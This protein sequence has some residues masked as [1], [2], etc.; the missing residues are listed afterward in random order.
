MFL[1]K[2][3]QHKE[4]ARLPLTHGNGGAGRSSLTLPSLSPTASS[5]MIIGGSIVVGCPS[6]S[7]VVVVVVVVVVGSV[8]RR[9]ACMFTTEGRS[10]IVAIR[11]SKLSAEARSTGGRSSVATARLSPTSS[12][13]APDV[14][15]AV[16]SATAA[17]DFGSAL[18]DLFRPATCFKTCNSSLSVPSDKK[19][20][21]DHVEADRGLVPCCCIIVEG[22]KVSTFDFV[23]NFEP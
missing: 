6:V 12:T 16:I 17:H 5:Y 1:L 7:I 15:G 14:V 19:E 22:D 23:L 2:C 21:A 4:H 13:N 10:S 9:S 11:G 8:V 3:A 18:E 20:S